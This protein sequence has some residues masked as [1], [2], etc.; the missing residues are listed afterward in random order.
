MT[1]EGQAKRLHQPGNSGRQPS[2]AGP[3]VSWAVPPEPS[4][5]GLVF[6]K[7]GVRSGF[8]GLFLG[9]WFFTVH[10]SDCVSTHCCLRTG[11]RWDV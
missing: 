7:K 9:I 5:P 4:F 8:L 10:V 11:S 2:V 6:L 1:A 3:T